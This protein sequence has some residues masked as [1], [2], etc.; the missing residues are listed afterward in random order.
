MKINAESGALS[1]PTDLHRPRPLP[2]LVHLGLGDTFTSTSISTR[3]RYTLITGSAALWAWR[4][5]FV[6]VALLRGR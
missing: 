5:D 4:R 3:C 2:S 6:R 1:A